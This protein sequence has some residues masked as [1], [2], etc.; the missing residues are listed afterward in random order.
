MKI[1]SENKRF[2]LA[3]LAAM[4]ACGPLMAHVKL[5]KIFSNNMMFQREQPV[6]VWGEA[7]S[8]EKI[9]IN[10]NSEVYRIKADKEGKWTI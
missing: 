5:P 10:F 4:I 2:T 6:R 3:V 7:D 8:G 1:S 9:E